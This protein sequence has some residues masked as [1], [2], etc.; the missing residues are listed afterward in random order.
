M[1]TNEKIHNAFNPHKK[2]GKKI[3]PFTKDEFLKIIRGTQFHKDL[4]MPLNVNGSNMSAGLWNL[5]LSERDCVMY[6]SGSGMKPHRFWKISDV[7]KYFNVRGSREVVAHT[8]SRLR[9]TITEHK[10]FEKLL[11]LK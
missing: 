7:K 2:D 6:A 4:F 3:E 1:N 10:N 8:M 9:V 5:L 11:D